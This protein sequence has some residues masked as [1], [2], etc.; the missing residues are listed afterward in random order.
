MVILLPLFAASTSNIQ[1]SSI[2]EAR[3]STSSVR[4]G[5]ML[6]RQPEPLV[7]HHE[8]WQQRKVMLQPNTS[9]SSPL[10]T[11]VPF[12]LSPSA[13]ENAAIANDQAGW[14][15]HADAACMLALNAL[16]GFTSNPSGLSTCYNIRTWDNE[17]G[18][19]EADLRLYRVSLSLDEWAKPDTSRTRLE[20]LYARAKVSMSNNQRMMRDI[21]E[22][23]SQGWQQGDARE[24]Y[25][26]RAC[27]VPPRKIMQLVLLGQFNN[28]AVAEFADE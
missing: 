8:Q 27:G 6:S 24:S 7:L 25:R 16:N 5:K 19:F 11:F 21:A 3:P 9:L 12:P 13:F 18:A 1:T 14:D 4:N 10:A 20:V 23:P 17:T 26:L 2:A 22:I 28:F 15:D